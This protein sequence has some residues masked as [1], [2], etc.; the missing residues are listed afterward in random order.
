MEPRSSSPTDEFPLGA[1]GQ[2]D[3]VVEGYHLV[4][5][6]I[7]RQGATLARS[8]AAFE[9][10]GIHELRLVTKRL[11]AL[12]QL[13]RPIDQTGVTIRAN[14]RLRD[15]AKL[16]ATARDD[17]VLHELLAELAEESTVHQKEYTEAATLPLASSQKHDPTEQDRETL[18]AV[19]ASDREDWDAIDPPGPDE[20]LGRGLAR[21]YTKAQRKGDRA[22]NSQE[23]DH[24]HEW[25]KWAKY[26]RYQL[27]PLAATD[28]PAIRDYHDDLKRLT[29]VL[30]RRNDLYNLRLGL[31]DR[32]V[33]GVLSDV[34]EHDR[35]L[36]D[37]LPAFYY[38]LFQPSASEFL[39]LV[40]RNV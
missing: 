24:F 23:L 19:L 15:A 14:D 17:F 38:K 11:R 25:R 40:V 16:L 20:L 7:G 30:G 10:E 35:M 28:R 4:P 1:I 27:E 5:V 9:P 37:R 22:L 6:Q 33:G 3:S 36:S 18:L 31:Q 13:H 26:L 39:K 12:W 21:T 2:R 34:A 8:D 29:S 32:Q